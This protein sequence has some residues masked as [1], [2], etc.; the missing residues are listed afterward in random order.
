MTRCW[1]TPHLL[2]RAR[3][4]VDHAEFIADEACDAGLGPVSDDIRLKSSRLQLAI[5]EAEARETEAR[6]SSTQRATAF[7]L[8]KRASNRLS[9]EIDVRLPFDEAIELLTTVRLACEPATRFR[10]DRLNTRQRSSLGSV[11]D[12]TDAALRGLD[13]AERHHF[14]SAARVNAARARATAQGHDLRADC[15]RVKALLL[16]SLEVNSDAW[17]RVSRRVIRTR[18]PDGYYARRLPPP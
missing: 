4:V 16:V 13:Q 3:V 6:L 10:L 11:V 14:E 17:R 9:L 12:D 7:S 18:R 2:D 15:E 1:T 8:L 5:E